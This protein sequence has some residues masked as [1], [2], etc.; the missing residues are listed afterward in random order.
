MLNQFE[1]A[2]HVKH[3]GIVPYSAYSNREVGVRSIVAV[4]ENQ[5]EPTRDTERLQARQVV[6]ARMPRYD[7]IAAMGEQ[8]IRASLTKRCD[9][10]ARIRLDLGR[11]NLRRV[12]NDVALPRLS[13]SDNVG[14]TPLVLERAAAER[15]AFSAFF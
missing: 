2:I 1:I 15:D 11:Y 4:K 10:V 14:R 6:G 8:P 5:P 13:N 7:K 3:V 12:A 9:Q